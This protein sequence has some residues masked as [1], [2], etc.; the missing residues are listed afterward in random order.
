MRALY[1]LGS[2]E[3]TSRNSDACVM[4]AKELRIVAKD[5][6][7]REPLCRVNQDE[8]LLDSCETHVLSL[9]LKQAID[10][11]LANSKTIRIV[12]KACPDDP[13]SYIVV[14]MRSPEVCRSELLAHLRSIEQQYWAVHLARVQLQASEEAR[15]I[16]AGV[17]KRTE[18]RPEPTANIA[19]AKEQLERFLLDVIEKSANLK[20]AE[21]QFRN[22][23]GLSAQDA[24]SVVCLS[25][26]RTEAPR[27]ETNCCD[28]DSCETFG[29]VFE[30]FEGPK[31][32]DEAEARVLG[33]ARLAIEKTHRLFQTAAKLDKAATVRMA[34]Q[35]AYY[36]NGSITIDRY[37]RIHP[38][39]GERDQPS[40][41]FCLSVQHGLS[42]GDEVDRASSW[43]SAGK[44]GRLNPTWPRRETRRR[45]AP[46]LSP[47][48]A[49]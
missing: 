37:P 3:Y 23:I 32:V 30:I 22:I 26:P 36:E 9:T 47:R 19:E 46:A 20:T 34:A 16:V 35:K 43:I 42:P 12:E 24:R 29:E 48:R 14:A 17:V 6:M 27:S 15:E 40:G 39:L 31:C 11:A 5:A 25:T 41:R 7:A 38:K 33:R 13:S 2:A 49:R 8:C 45:L 21:R 4:D 1:G 10:M 18:S 28:D 44:S